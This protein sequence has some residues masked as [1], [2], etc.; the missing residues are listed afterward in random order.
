MEHNDVIRILKDKAD[1]SE[2]SIWENRIDN[3][4][5]LEDYYSLL[6]NKKTLLGN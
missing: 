6:E 3:K 4:R 1:R 2:Y 5:I